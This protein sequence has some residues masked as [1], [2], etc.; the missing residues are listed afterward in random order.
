[1]EESKALKQQVREV[2]GKKYNAE[3]AVEPKPA[4]YGS[5]GKGKK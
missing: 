1:M 4:E 3:I 5:K 2:R